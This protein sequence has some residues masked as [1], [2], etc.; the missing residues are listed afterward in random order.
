L[1]Q[2]GYLQINQNIEASIN[3]ILK[4][5]WGNLVAVLTK[6]FGTYNMQLAEDV[7]QDTFIKAIE[8]W[9]EQGLPQNPA[10]WLYT[11]ARNKATDVIRKQKREQQHFA[12]HAALLQSEY[13]LTATIHTLVNDLTLDD[14]RLRMMFVCCHPLLS[15][16]ASITLILKTICGLTVTEIAK[17]FLTEYDTIE[18]RLY[19]ARQTFK[20]NRIGF[21]L[22]TV[23]VLEDRLERVLTCIY[24]LFNEGYSSTQ[25]EYLVRHDLMLEAMELCELILRSKAVPHDEAQALMALMCFTAARND[26]RTDDTGNILLLKDQD[27]TKWNKQLI[28]AG[29]D[30]LDAAANGAHLSKYHLEAGI[31]Y[32]HVKCARYEDTNWERI[33]VCYNLLFQLKPSPVVALN[34]AIAISELYGAAEGIKAIEHI[35]GIAFLKNYYVLPATLGVL[36]L[37][38]QEYSIAKAYFEMALQLTKSVTEQ[39]LL[40]QKIKEAE[41]TE[42]LVA[43]Q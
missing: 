13:S 29:I 39:R 20:E 32:E 27:R 24:L 34:R 40:Q 7:V 2:T 28:K 30:H 6:V 25:N 3:H 23:T 11:V 9:N 12:E 36:H 42:L 33:I 5:E 4:Q 17:A 41:A 10:A 8:H 19:R 37:Q 43:V 18:K 15:S 14:D 35:E 22:P 31:A 1:Q 38:I 21:E 16:E 26:A